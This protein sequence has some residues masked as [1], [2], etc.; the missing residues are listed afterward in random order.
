MCDRILVMFSMLLPL[1][2]LIGILLAAWL[3]RASMQAKEVA[4]CAA[5][6]A[7]EKHNL[8]FLD[9]TVALKSIKFKRDE[10][11]S[12]C[13][14]RHYQF[15]YYDGEQIRKIST[16]D[17]LGNIVIDVELNHTTHDESNVIQ[18]H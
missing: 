18:L 3:W 4:T 17:L 12:P 16:I 7:C 9:E 2:L 6:N 10:M 5:E 11:G 15:E 13:L 8:Q 14:L 1:L